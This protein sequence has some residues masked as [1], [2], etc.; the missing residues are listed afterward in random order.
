MD[1]FQDKSIMWKSIKSHS[2]PLTLKM[3]FWLF[4]WF[5]Y[6]WKPLFGSSWMAA[7]YAQPY[8]AIVLCLPGCLYG[9]EMGNLLSPTPWL[10]Q[11]KCPALG[12]TTVLSSTTPL[13]HTLL[14][15][16][17]LPSVQ[18]LTPHP[19]CC[20]SMLVYCFP[21]NSSFLLVEHGERGMNTAVQMPHKLQHPLIRDT[22]AQFLLFMDIA[23]FFLI[24]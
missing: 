4:I 7:F 22:A 15:K 10:W 12:C 14:R 6:F 19:S 13:R 21:G 18:C 8:L 3:P 5:G 9:N 1:L 23:I 24:Q 17:T 16:T 20:S 11:E 2:L